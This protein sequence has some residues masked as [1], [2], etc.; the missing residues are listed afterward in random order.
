MS[1]LGLLGAL[2]LGFLLLFFFFVLFLFLLLLLLFLLGLRLRGHLWG[3]VLGNNDF[4]GLDLRLLFFIRAIVLA[5][6]VFLIV[7]VLLNLSALPLRLGFRGH[8]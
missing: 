4:R 8:Q 6:H 2:R 1:L 3:I 7:I 5:L